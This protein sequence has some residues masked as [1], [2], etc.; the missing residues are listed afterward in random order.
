M[1]RSL[2][3]TDIE[4]K[5]LYLS[6]DNFRFFPFPDRSQTVQ[7]S[8]PALRYPCFPF[9]SLG[10]SLQGKW[11]LRDSFPRTDAA[12][13]AD[14]ASFLRVRC[15]AIFHGPTRQWAP[16]EAQGAARATVIQGWPADV[17]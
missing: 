8:P 12:S 1:H 11:A 7:F 17:C 5:G 15:A 4:H 9:W 6:K 16:P 14:L 3:N 2:G 10:P 13:P